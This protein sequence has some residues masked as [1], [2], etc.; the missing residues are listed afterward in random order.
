MMTQGPL[1]A[2]VG[3]GLALL[4]ALSA[5][6]AFM[7]SP[8]TSMTVLC[9]EALTALVSLDLGLRPHEHDGGNER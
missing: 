9:A 2:R 7:P 6:F 5:L 1:V 4:G 3:S 8:T